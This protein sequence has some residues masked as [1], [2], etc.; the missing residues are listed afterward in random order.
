MA[1]AYSNHKTFLDIKTTEKKPEL[2]YSTKNMRT[3][4]NTISSKLPDDWVRSMRRLA[5]TYDQ[6]T[7]WL[8]S[9]WRLGSVAMFHVERCGSTVLGNLLN[10]HPKICWDNE[11]VLKHYINQNCDLKPFDTKKFFRRQ[12]LVAGRRFYGFEIKIHKKQQ[13]AIWHKTHSELL[14]ELIEIGINK[15][16]ILE[17]KNY[18][19]RMISQIV[20]SQ[21][22]IRGAI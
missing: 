19:R 7:G 22:S 18:L 21:T 15:F 8:T 14:E 1:I 11:I 9:P 3:F 12:M 2:N 13:L 6:A 5:R 10:Q 16:I 17:R 4:R 20:G